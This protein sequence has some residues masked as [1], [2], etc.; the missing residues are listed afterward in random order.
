V[1]DQNHGRLELVMS[2]NA[3]DDGT[4]ESCRQFARSDLFKVPRRTSS[5]PTAASG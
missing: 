5:G 1:P 2:D 4:E 3:W